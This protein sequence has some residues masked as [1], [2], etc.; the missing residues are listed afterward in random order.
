MR[1]FRI[2]LLTLVAAFACQGAFAADPGFTTLS[3]E[4]LLQLEGQPLPP[5]ADLA[6]SGLIPGRYAD[7]KSIVSEMGYITAWLGHYNML[8]GTLDDDLVGEAAIGA[9]CYGNN[10]T[11]DDAAPYMYRYYW[12]N[13]EIWTGYYNA[14]NDAE[15]CESIYTDQV[16]YFVTQVKS[17]TRRTA[18][19]LVGADEGIKVWL[20]GVEVMRHED[21]EYV[22]DEFST[23]VELKEGWNLVVV[24]V[25][26]PLIGPQEHP[27]YEQKRWAL[28]FADAGGTTPLH[29]AQATDGWCDHDQTYQWI[30][31]GGVADLPGAQGS[32]WASDLRLT[33]LYHYPLEL[34]PAVLRG[35][36]GAS[37]AGQDRFG[38]AR[39]D[40]LE[41]GDARRRTD[42][43]PRPV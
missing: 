4:A 19:M 34:T 6:S 35:G 21:G 36:L 38:G 30:Y 7:A 42:D 24:K 12:T 8:L 40:D 33:N 14:F 26:Y 11:E 17:P 41:C 13:P 9:I 31:A 28:R 29:L 27:D 10:L 15:A 43:R 23:Q 1:T 32:Q 5:V 18:R 16:R 37:G 3:S 2:T 39:V 25:Y 22:V 20:N